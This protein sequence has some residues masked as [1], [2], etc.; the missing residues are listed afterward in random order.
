MIPLSSRYRGCLVGHAV[1]DALGAPVEFLS[2][3]EIVSR[4]GPEGVRGM[5]PW[6]TTSRG[7]PA[8]AYTDDTQMML[9]TAGGLLEAVGIRA[10]TGFCQ[11]SEVVHAHYLD[12]L[13]DQ[14]DPFLRRGP[15][16]TCLAALASGEAG[17]AFDPLNDSKGAGGIMRIAPAGLA[18]R[19]VQAFESA[20]ELAA[21]THGHPSGYLAAGAYAE[22]LARV[23]SGAEPQVAVAE[24]RQVLIGYDAADETLEAL[25]TSVELFITDAPFSEAFETLGEGWVAEEALGLSLYFALGFPGDFAEGILAAVNHDGD[26]DTTGALTG[27][28]L[29]AML[30]WESIPGDW[31]REVEDAGRI[32]EV[33][34]ALYETFVEEA[35][36]RLD[37][38]DG[39]GY[40]QGGG[41]DGG[42]AG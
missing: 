27:G 41:P 22:V 3:R 37:G 23:V 16:S 8:G 42:I 38:L 24:T 40:E 5:H 31:V 32:I 12:W 17:S 9:A 34:D 18:F 13:A 36:D 29:G 11:D 15:G 7:F 20:M 4:F 35:P 19:P 10:E 33:A 28:L 1:G 2:L 30:G 26:S 21:L 14:E 25:D 39:S 6:E